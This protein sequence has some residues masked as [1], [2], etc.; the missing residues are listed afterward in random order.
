MS[1][2]CSHLKPYKITHPKLKQYYTK[3]FILCEA[4]HRKN[5]KPMHLIVKIIKMIN[6]LT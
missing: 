4:K 6:V 2:K 1:N 5:I 3:Q